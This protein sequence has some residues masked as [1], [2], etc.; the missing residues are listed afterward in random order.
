MYGV[1]W[2]IAVI[3]ALPSGSVNA[4]P[5]QLIVAAAATRSVSIIHKLG[6]LTVNN[7]TTIRC[8]FLYLTIIR[9]DLVEL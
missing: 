9:S 3:Q 6:E 7:P 8:K 2:H 4:F 5:H 1:L